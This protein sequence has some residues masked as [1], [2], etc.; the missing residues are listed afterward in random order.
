MAFAYNYR[1]QGAV[2]GTRKGFDPEFAHLHPGLVLQK[3]MLEDGLRRG[4][5]VYDLG[6]GDHHSKAPWRTNVRTSY[7][8]TFF[9]AMVLRAQLLRCNRWFRRQLRGE[10]DIAC[11][12][13]RGKMRK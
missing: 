7:R 2:H 6:T 3:I 5:R 9:P 4:D 8:F 10:H 11:S 13:G 12:P 1:W